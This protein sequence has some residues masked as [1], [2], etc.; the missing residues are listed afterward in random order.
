MRKDE[1]VAVFK[2]YANSFPAFRDWFNSHD[3]SAQIL[4]RWCSVIKDC[5]F[6]DCMVVVQKFQNGDLESPKRDG[7]PQAIRLGARDIRAKRMERERMERL[8]EAAVG[9]ISGPNERIYS[10]IKLSR[11]AGTALAN[12]EIDHEQN[13]DYLARVKEWCE[14]GG[15][16]PFL[17]PVVGTD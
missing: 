8:H 15:P 14:K 13:E 9:G 2:S 12:K 11:L 3:D 16:M 5:D 1:A 17:E 6:D 10:A 7:L 4:E